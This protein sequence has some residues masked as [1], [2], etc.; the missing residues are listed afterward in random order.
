MVDMLLTGVVITFVPLVGWGSNQ[1]PKS[2]IAANYVEAYHVNKHCRKDGKKL[3]YHLDAMTAREADY[4]TIFLYMLPQSLQIDLP[5][6]GVICWIASKNFLWL[7]C[8]DEAHTVHQDGLFCLE[9]KFAIDTLCRNHGLLIVKCS[10]IAMSATFQKVDQDVITIL[11][12]RPP[13]MVMWLES[14][15]QQNCFNAV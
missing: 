12:G 6:Y 7:V 15:H 14:S 4:V 3:R 1:V 13:S 11:L 9:F 5:R 2:C 10:I 8:M